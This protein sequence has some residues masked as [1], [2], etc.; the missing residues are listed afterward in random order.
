MCGP[1]WHGIH[2]FVGGSGSSTAY[3]ATNQYPG[4][5]RSRS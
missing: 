2:F 1:T 5:T 3:G 4:A